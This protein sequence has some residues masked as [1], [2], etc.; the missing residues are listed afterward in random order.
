[1]KVGNEYMN[2][3]SIEDKFNTL[4]N[5]LYNQHYLELSKIKNEEKKEKNVR[6]L[7]WISYAVFIIFS[8]YLLGTIFANI[9]STALMLIIIFVLIA[10]L[11]I[12]GVL[13]FIKFNKKSNEFYEKYCN[14]VYKF[15]LESVNETWK[16]SLVKNTTN[17]MNDYDDAKLPEKKGG[18]I[19][20]LAISDNFISNIFEATFFTLQIPDPSGVSSDY[21]GVYFSILNNNKILNDIFVRSKKHDTSL[22]NKP[23]V[24]KL[25]INTPNHNIY[26]K[27][28][29]NIPN[30][31]I[32]LIN[33]F[34]STTN[35]DCDMTITKT[36]IQIRFNIIRNYPNNK[37]ILDRNILYKF[38]YEMSLINQFIE[39]LIKILSH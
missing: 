15:I 11:G 2:T 19:G 10:I 8:F 3:K 35:I 37:N 20:G 39:E 12:L 1:M 27:E 16:Y 29:F 9:D 6:R 32:D 25:N 26:S 4:Y 31:L 34:Y 21:E 13:I 5:E 30:G 7:L 17:I 18:R 14:I 28:E 38:F 24:S 22:Y 36:K 23:S 33:K